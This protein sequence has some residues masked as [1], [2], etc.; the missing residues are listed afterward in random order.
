MPYMQNHHECDNNKHRLIPECFIND[1][2]SASSIT[3]GN[4]IF[5]NNEQLL[6]RFLSKTEYYLT[7][8]DRAVNSQKIQYI[9]KLGK[10]CFLFI[11]MMDLGSK[12]RLLC[13]DHLGDI[14]KVIQ[15]RRQCFQCLVDPSIIENLAPLAS[16]H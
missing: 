9:L 2:K 12:F 5:C 7:S 15:D 10:K 4:M 1:S 11:C 6:V 13:T 8:V 3:V 16:I 14:R